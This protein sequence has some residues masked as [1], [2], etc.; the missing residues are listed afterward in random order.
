MMA[1]HPLTPDKP[2][3]LVRKMNHFGGVAIS[4]EGIEFDGAEA[5]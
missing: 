5:R 1:E 2:R 3:A 4:L